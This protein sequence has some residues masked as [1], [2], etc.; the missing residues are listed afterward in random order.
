MLTQRLLFGSLLLITTIGLVLFDA[1]LSPGS[2]WAL[3][4]EPT[5]VPVGWVNGLPLACL[6]G[7]LVV[8]GTY[9]LSQLFR[10]GGYRPVTY[11]AAFVGAGLV[12]I[13]WI[14]MQLRVGTIQPG[15]L[16][17][18]MPSSFGAFW[19]AG[20]LM[21]VVLN[22][23]ARKTTDQAA[24][25]MAITLF[26]LLYLGLLGSFVVRIRCDWP[27]AGGAMLVAYCVLT[28][29]FG[30]IGAYFVGMSF[31]KHKL[32]PWLSPGKTIEGLF[33]AFLFSIAISLG[34]M[35]LWGVLA[36]G[37]E[38]LLTRSQSIVFAVVM[39]I[40]GHLGDLAESAIKRD[41]G[42]KDSGRILPA[43]GGILDILDSALFAAPIAWWLLTCWV[44]I[45]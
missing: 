1:W 41:V 10:A 13:P 18:Q 14:E 27:G 21:G 25:N 42:I 9:E 31:G 5:M 20:G 22:V 45:G 15:V 7:V 38:P 33:G 37:G 29:K 44:R 19:L 43:F 3:A 35:A 39:T 6:V 4:L 8:A 28:V 17:S 32:A 11:W 40:V 23:L 12:M 24:G 2:L 30:D 36:P 16:F 26:I 34:M